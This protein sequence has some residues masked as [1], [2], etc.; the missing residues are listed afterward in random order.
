MPVVI[1]FLLVTGCAT[2]G[3]IRQTLPGDIAGIHFQCM[4]PS[5]EI[6]AATDDKAIKKNLPRANIISSGRRMIPYPSS[7]RILRK[8][9]AVEKEASF[10]N[11]IVARL[12]G[13]LT[14]LKEGETRHVELTA[15]DIPERKKEDYVIRLARV[16]ESPM[17]IKMTID[18]FKFRT[19][20]V[21]RTEKKISYD[22]S[23]DGQVKRLPE[24]KWLSGYCRRRAPW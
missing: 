11:D 24:R 12:A 18:Q 4:L 3:S 13:Q 2:S 7:F 16:R 19:G 1:A 15:Q 17:E 14:G 23:F 8:K 9:P 22:S 21:S 5:G 6:A 10:E 20:S